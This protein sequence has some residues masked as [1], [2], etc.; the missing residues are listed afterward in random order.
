[1]AKEESQKQDKN[2]HMRPLDQAH[3]QK[4]LLQFEDKHISLRGLSIVLEFGCKKC[5]NTCKRSAC[6][7][8]HLCTKHHWGHSNNSA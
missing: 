2:K 6:P 5:N 8:P 3:G 4:V 1:M 7:M